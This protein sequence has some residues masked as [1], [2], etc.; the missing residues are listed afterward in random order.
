[1]RVAVR[2]LVPG[3]TDRR[4]L[5]L[6][7]PVVLGDEGPT[8]LAPARATLRLERAGNVVRVAGAVTARVQLACDLCLAPVHRTI[9]AAVDEEVVL[10]AGTPPEAVELVAA[11]FLTPIG[12][13]GDLDVAALVREHLLMAVPMSVRCRDECRG[14]CPQCGTNRNE[15]ECGHAAHAVDPRLAVL[16]RLLE[17]SAEEE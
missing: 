16:G 3:P 1:M 8:L 7:L 11:S 2:D 13:A 12:D 5:D 6:A 14:L 17:R 15:R 9:D 10:A 4:D